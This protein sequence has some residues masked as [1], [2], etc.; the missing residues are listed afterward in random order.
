[1][2]IYCMHVLII[3]YFAVAWPNLSG[4][5][6]LKLKNKIMILMKNDCVTLHFD[7]EKIFIA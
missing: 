3:F 7:M 5:F 1:M 2:C 6:I 4:I